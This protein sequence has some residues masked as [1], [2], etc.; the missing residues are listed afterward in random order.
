MTAVRYKPKRGQIH[1]TND[2][3][4]QGVTL[5]E[6]PGNVLSITGIFTA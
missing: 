5:L 3:Y 4:I 1:E 6:N 2:G